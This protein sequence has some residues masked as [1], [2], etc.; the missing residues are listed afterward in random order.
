MTPIITLFF[1]RHDSHITDELANDIIQVIIYAKIKE[2]ITTRVEVG[3]GSA[4]E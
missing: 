2:S 3:L 4:F 1:S